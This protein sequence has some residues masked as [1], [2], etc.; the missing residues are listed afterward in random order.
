LAAAIALAAGSGNDADISSVLTQ[1]NQLLDE[2]IAADGFR[3][4]ER[5]DGRAIIDLAKI[6]FDALAKRFAKSTR[7][8]VDLEQLKAAIRAQLDKLIRLNRTR[9]DYLAKFEELIESYNS[10]SRNIQELFEELLNFTRAL[11]EEE[12]R[13]VRENLSEQ[14]LTIF[15]ILTRPGPNLSAE[16]REEVKKVARQLLQRLKALLVVDWR[17]RAQARA[18]IRLAIEDSLDDGLPRSYSPELY[19][20]KCSAVFEHVFEAFGSEQVA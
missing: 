17:Q 3:I 19:K 18:Q 2:S 6:D 20:Q 5:D 16:E 13:H 7:K 11:T 10:G 8:N 1:V 9:A 4:R 12:Q 14:E 15:D